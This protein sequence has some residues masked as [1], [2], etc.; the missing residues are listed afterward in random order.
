VISASLQTDSETGQQQWVVSSI[1]RGQSHDI[2]GLVLL[3]K[4]TLLSGGVTTDICL[5]K[6]QDGRFKDQFGKNSMQQRV[7]EKVRHIPPFPFTQVAKLESDL[8]IMLNGSGHSFDIF[9]VKS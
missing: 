6:L 2:K 3:N 9:S 4:N 1:F 5:Y 8:M 7:Q